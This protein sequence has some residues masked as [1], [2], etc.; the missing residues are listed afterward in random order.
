MSIKQ[1]DNLQKNNTQ[2]WLQA[3][4]LLFPLIIY[5]NTIG[6]DYA[7]DDALVITHNQFTQKGFDGLKDIFTNDSF[8]GF[9]KEKK[10]HLPGGR[11]RPLS[12]ATFAIEHEFFGNNSHLSHLI[13]IL[14]FAFTGFLLYR[15]LRLF[16]NSKDKS[17]ALI[18]IPV[19][20]T[21]I[22]LAHPIHTEVVANIKG[23]DEILSLFFALF[24][25]MS[26]IKY[27]D[28]RQWHWLF[29]GFASF[30]LALLSKENA[31]TFILIIPLSIYFFRDTSFR[32]LF[33]SSIPAVLAAIVFFL[34]R[35]SITGGFQ[36]DASVDLMNN[37][38]L[39]ATKNQEFATI[40]LTLG[41]YLKLLLWPHPLTFDYYP[42][43]IALT[44]WH[45]IGV[46]ITLVGYISLIIYACVKF[47]DKKPVAYSILFFIISLLPVSNLFV[48]IGTFMNERFVYQASVAFS[49]G[50]SWF[51]LNIMGKSV[52]RKAIYR[53]YIKALVLVAI[54]LTFSMV[55]FSRNFVWKNDYT[56]FLTDVKTSSNS[57]KSN[58]G[59]G[60]VLLDTALAT[61]DSIKRKD[62]LTRSIQFLTKAASIDPSYSDVWR[63]LGTAQYE[64][65]HDIHKAFQYYCTAIR[66]NPGDEKS[67]SN[68]HFILSKYDSIDSKI[69]MYIELLRI[70]PMRPE[71]NT[72]LGLIYGKE[73]HDIPTAITY[74]KQSVKLNPTYKEAYKGMGAAYLL[75]GDY[76]ESFRCLKKALRLDTLDA[77]TYK[78]MGT[79]ALQMGN[80]RESDIFLS[81]ANLLK[82]ENDVSK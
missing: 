34:I 74:F 73:K 39:Y 38:F 36:I 62:E 41:I 15:V 11:Y 26:G 72:Q 46:I 82:N 7:L 48:N 58:C 29:I 61:D 4:I 21:I 64:I 33:A 60:G 81:K 56:L 54:I 30:F 8:T 77:G 5:S 53:Q 12:I 20:A 3:A 80:K 14:L 57:A 35:N 9:L 50:I 49:V 51:L 43:H 13:N 69:D 22:F 66:N 24:A 79:T 75:V 68:I 67:Y 10:I 31:I 47:S 59:A 17:V 55:T 76:E 44:N 71:I 25:L 40:I 16:F 6:H 52:I 1:K 32:R 19:L 65:N 70:N 2:F 28:E 27:T 63:K 18:N 42:Y 45:N 37:P 23:R 78:L